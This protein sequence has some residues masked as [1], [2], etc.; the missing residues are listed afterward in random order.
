MNLSA[1]QGHTYM[2]V[3]YFPLFKS[4]P[5]AWFFHF[6]LG[7]YD[8]SSIFPL[9]SGTNATLVHVSI[10][11]CLWVRHD[12]C[13]NARSAF[14]PP[15]LGLV[16]KRPARPELRPPSRNRR[17]T[18]WPNDRCT[19]WPPRRRQD[20]WPEPA[21]LRLRLRAADTKPHQTE[22]IT[23]AQSNRSRSR[24]RCEQHF[25]PRVS[26]RTFVYKK[27][28]FPKR[29]TKGEHQKLSFLETDETIGL[30]KLSLIFHVALFFTFFIEIA[31]SGVLGN[32]IYRFFPLLCPASE[33]L[34][35]YTR[36]SP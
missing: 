10:R 13:A 33:I 5:K 30:N 19:V 18:C 1:L 36:M 3:M 20:S 23:T 4:H 27:K 26:R 34:S 28:E 9:F 7:N 31:F 16:P 35:F 17:V 2:L 15:P 24:P 6:F 14:A 21:A 8:I 12:P 29:G 25:Q 22:P 32:S 11:I